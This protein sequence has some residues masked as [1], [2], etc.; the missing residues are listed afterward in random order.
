M[1]KTIPSDER[2]KI[3]RFLF[4]TFAI[5]WGTEF[6]LIA[7]YRFQIISGSLGLFFHFAT[8][9]F[10]AG[11]APAYAAFTVERRD[12]KITLRKFCKQIFYSFGERTI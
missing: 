11:L 2:R 4:Y 9:A 3:C 12:K 10:G 1:S 7:A 8:I 5:A 6:L